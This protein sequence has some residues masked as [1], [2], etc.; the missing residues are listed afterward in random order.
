MNEFKS[1]LLTGA[2]GFLGKYIYK[3]LLKF[4]SV[5]TLARSSS[6]WNVD[7]SK[8]KPVFDKYYDLVVHNAGK[9]HSVPLTE[10]ERKLFYDVNLR[11]T[12]N[13]LKSIDSS[14]QKP[15]AFVF[16]ST[17]AVYG[18][19]T[20][21]DIQED[22]PLKATEPYGK[23]KILA[24]QLVTSWCARNNVVCSILRLPLIAGENA[25]GNLGA[26]VKSIKKGYYFNIG[27]GTAR[28]SMVLAQDV[29]Q[30]IIPVAKVGGIYNLTDSYHPS[31]SELSLAISSQLKKKE[32][33]LNMPIAVARIFGKVGDMLGGYAPINS[34]KIQKITSDLTFN[35]DKARSVLNWNP[36][37]VIS[38]LHL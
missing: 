37:P 30:I 28:K 13:L 29:A 1:M 27:G 21:V 10:A 7:L 3:E 4:G 32:A 24:E 36:T 34:A 9:A 14:G 17:V 8:I 6:T 12:E 15:Q 16:I 5:E 25:P 23:S 33:A 38:G 20:G 11:G 2:N 18:L 31:F 22:Q 35:D 19:E 26:M